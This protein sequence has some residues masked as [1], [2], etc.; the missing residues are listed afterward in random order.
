MTG[1]PPDPDPDE[2][3]DWEHAEDG[4]DGEDGEDS[5]EPGFDFSDL[6]AQA[7]SFQQRLVE[8]Q[9]A[10]AEQV[11]EGHA[12]GGVVKVRVTGGFDFLEVA[13]DPGVVDPVEVEMLQDLVLAAVRDAV[14]R[15]N[16]INQAAIG[17]VGD[18]GGMLP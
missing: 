17:G 10:V 6:L 5:G 2:R 1:T 11:V 15:A 3:D 13:I 18:L 12:G 7:H 14:A 9:A 16:E 8:A 4:E